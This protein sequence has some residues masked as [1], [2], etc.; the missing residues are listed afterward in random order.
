MS[1][2][3]RAK[4]P[5][6]DQ[7]YCLSAETVI[8]R[9]EAQEPTTGSRIRYIAYPGSPLKQN[10]SAL[11]IIEFLFSVLVDPASI[12][13]RKPATCNTE[14]EENIESQQS[15]DAIQAGLYIKNFESD[16]MFGGVYEEVLEQDRRDKELDASRGDGCST[17]SK[18]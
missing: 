3:N 15:N 14:E 16:T 9:L 2:F 7:P 11:L 17:R 10:P 12:S 8:A 18:Y 5:N 4:Y 13:P 6:S 1:I